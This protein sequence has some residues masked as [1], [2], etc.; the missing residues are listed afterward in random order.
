MAEFGI[1]EGV[2]EF[3]INCLSLLLQ[4]LDLL[5]DFHSSDQQLL[6][7]Q[8]RQMREGILSLSRQG[9]Q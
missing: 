2:L 3:A 6:H 7:G 5:G 8:F 1:A 4:G 9:L